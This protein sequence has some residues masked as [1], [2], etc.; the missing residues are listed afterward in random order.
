MKRWIALA[1]SLALG[2]SL[3]LSGLAAEEGLAN[4]TRSAEAAEPFAD[5]AEDAWYAAPVADARA[6]GLVQG[7]GEGEPEVSPA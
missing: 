1:L 6:L 2:L 5:V 4:F 3:S 7:V